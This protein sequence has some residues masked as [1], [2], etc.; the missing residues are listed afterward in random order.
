[1]PLYCSAFIHYFSLRLPNFGI[2]YWSDVCL[3]F[4]IDAQKYVEVH[5]FF[6]SDLFGPVSIVMVCAIGGHKK[7]CK[8]AQAVLFGEQQTWTADSVHTHCNC[9]V[10]FQSCGA[11]WLACLL[12]VFWVISNCVAVFRRTRAHTHTMLF[13]CICCDITK[14]AADCVIW[15]LFFPPL[16]SIWSNSWSGGGASADQGL[17][18]RFGRRHC[19]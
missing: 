8:S 5:C 4:K 14:T 18:S 11:L 16:Q 9:S 17:G 2:F 13:L 3:P 6:C 15:F 10:G 19:G 7:N 12:T 1:M